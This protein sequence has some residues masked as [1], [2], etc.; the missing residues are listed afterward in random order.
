VP[1]T[2]GSQP[3]HS[4]PAQSARLICLLTGKY[5]PLVED[6]VTRRTPAS[7]RA[8]TPAAGHPVHD[9][10]SVARL[11]SALGRSSRL[12]RE[13]AS[14]G[15]T[16]SQ[17][18]VLGALLRE[19]PR[20]LT[21]LSIAERINPTLLSRV[22]GRLE[23]DGFVLRRPHEQDRRAYLL[24]ITDKGRALAEGIR[25]ERCQALT[26]RLTRIDPAQVDTLFG[27]LTA[28]EALADELAVSQKD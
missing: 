4:E 19:G 26:E 16:P 18:A 21:E 5:F 28:L 15:L 9:T 14:G 11:Q 13:R 3:I 6:P 2:A 20:Q 10:D 1:K 17:L 25:R 23:E 24:S 7:S 22:V 8:V 12:L 27:A